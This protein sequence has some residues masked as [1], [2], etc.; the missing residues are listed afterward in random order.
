MK[1]NYFDTQQQTN[2]FLQNLE[3]E[4]WQK[5]KNPQPT[6]SELNNMENVFCKATVL[7]NCK[8]PLNNLHY[9]NLQGA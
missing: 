3:Y 5:D 1:M 4:E 6:E 2:N 9:N 8:T 7:K